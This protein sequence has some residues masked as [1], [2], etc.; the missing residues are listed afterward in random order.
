MLRYPRRVLAVALLIFAVLGVIGLNVEEQLAPSSLDISGTD[1]SRANEILRDHFGETATFAILLRGPT[2]EINRQGQNLVRVFREDPAVTTLSPW[3][4]GSVAALR[5]SPRRAL[6]VVDFHVGVE[7]AVNEK[8]DLVNETLAEHVHSP[9]VSTQTGFATISRAIQDESISAS[10]RSELIALP[11]LLIVLLLVFR[12]P[13]AAAIPLAFGATTVF[14]S[15]GLLSLLTHW[16]TVDALALTVCTM[17]GLALGVDYALLIVSRFREELR[18]GAD[19]IDAAIVTRRT[20]G[21]TVIFAGSTLVLSMT[22]AFFVVPGALL[23]SLAATLAMVVVLSVLVA[24]LIGPPLLVMVG[25]NID[26]WRIGTP[27]ADESRSR[28]MIMVSAALRRPAPVAAVIGLIVLVLAAPAVALKTGPLSPGQLP[29]DD[30]AREDYDLITQ[31]IGAGFDAP[32]TIVAATDHGAITDPDTLSALTRWQRKIANTPG[33]QAVVG[34]DQV[35]KSVKP[36]Q[37]FGNSV[38]A[39]GDASPLATLDRLGVNLGRAATG[40]TALR[41]GISQAT[42]GAGLLVDGSGQAEDGAVAIAQGLG[43]ATSGSERIVKALDKS[44]SGA[45]RLADAQEQAAVGSFQIKVGLKNEVRNLRN[46]PLARSRKLQKTLNEESKLKVPTLIP[47]AQ[48][49]QQQLQAALDQLGAMTVGKTDPNYDAALA[50][51]R[52]AL[53]AVSGTNPA[54][55]QPY[56]AEYTGLPN[57]LTELQKRLAKDTNQ[58]KLIT[59]FLTSEI[60]NLNRL[61]S[62]ANRLNDGLNQI[63]A[64]GKKLSSGATQLSDAMGQ[65]NDGLVQLGSATDSLSGGLSQLVGGTTE[66][67]LSLGEAYHRS[68]P[69]QSGLRR[70][71]ARVVANNASLNRRVDRVRNQTPGIFD[72]GYFVLSALDGARGSLRDQAAT[73]VDV[74]NGGQA[75]SLF[76]IPRYGLNSPGSIALN[77]TLDEDAKAL[78]EEA[79]LKT[80]VAGG[81][82]QLN[83]YSR[84]ARDRIPIVVTAITIATFL[85]MLLVLRA[86]PLAAIAV[87]LNLASVAVAFGVLTL[88]FNVPEGWPLGGRTYVDAVGATMMFGVIFGLSIDYAVFL[89]VRMREHYEQHGDNAEAIKFGL[90]KT[91]RVITGAA[92]IMLAVFIAFAGAPIA[93]TSQLGVGLTVAVFLDATVVRIVL[94]PALM[95]LAGDRVWWLPKWLDRAMPKLNVE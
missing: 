15:S 90:E 49:A 34:P 28:L 33:V 40:V 78:G 82:A 85:V 37:R 20:A 42:Y 32:F 72:S 48:D 54:T 26:R 46:N 29:H 5:P 69:L 80:G 45:E 57:E 44:V 71:Q 18:G 53:A 13:I 61:S 84:V 76:V 30:P 83:T 11:I 12:S 75:A 79:D 17:M 88:L 4:R 92:T 70:I 59:S 89:L 6:V 16:F 23:A 93:T 50:A 52:Q 24:I 19:P 60:G 73:A 68:Y 14:V 2:G 77:K 43:K 51:V 55:G 8:V 35:A 74:K 31:T 86:I 7:E 87:G 39:P 67:Q 27:P 56:A 47:P 36:L 64:A 65:L 63:A 25:S 94:L 10:E 9:V 38:L 21:K 91:A 1:A 62:N 81:T 22:V 58:S 41:D 66:L 3:D 95:L